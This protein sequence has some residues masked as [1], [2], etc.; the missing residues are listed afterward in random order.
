MTTANKNA[1]GK[2]EGIITSPPATC[3]ADGHKTAAGHK[4]AYHMIHGSMLLMA[5]F[6][7]VCGSH[8]EDKGNIGSAWFFYAMVFAAVI[9]LEFFTWLEAE[10]DRDDNLPNTELCHA[11]SLANKQPKGK[12]P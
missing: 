2:P 3:S 10:C 4:A 8:E 11:A 7:V 12:Q 9:M 6:G 5:I 1:T